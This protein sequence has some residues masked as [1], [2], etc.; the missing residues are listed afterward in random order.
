MTDYS[1]LGRI[2]PVSSDSEERTVL[3]ISAVSSPEHIAAEPSETNSSHR[4]RL[5][6]THSSQFPSPPPSVTSSIGSSPHYNPP[7]P[8]PND[9]L[10]PIYARIDK[11]NRD[12]VQH[13]DPKT[14]RPADL[15]LAIPVEDEVGVDFICRYR[16]LP[17]RQLLHKVEL[18]DGSLHI[19]SAR[20]GGAKAYP[21]IA[22]AALRK[23]LWQFWFYEKCIPTSLYENAIVDI[24]SYPLWINTEHHGAWATDYTPDATITCDSSSV[25][26]PFMVEVANTQ[27]YG[28]LQAK[29][30]FWQHGSGGKVKTIILMT[31]ANEDVV[32]DH[33]CVLE[34]WKCA[35]RRTP[36]DPWVFPDPPPGIS[37]DDIN[38]ERQ[39]A[40]DAT[41]AMQTFLGY[42][43]GPLYW[44]RDHKPALDTYS[45]RSIPL[46]ASD[47]FGESLDFALLPNEHYDPNAECHIDLELWHSAIKKGVSESIKR[48]TAFADV[49]FPTDTTTPPRPDLGRRPIDQGKSLSD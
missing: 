25:W 44:I 35:H 4:F 49:P 36:E 17:D 23:H 24:Q 48:K 2:S 27:K 1:H 31:Y 16:S 28:D 11:H 39:K 20:M 37:L 26:A 13:F 29:R 46:R 10:A 34:V 30:S 21:D 43:E 41:S 7:S 22:P 45:H 33:T 19:T 12:T 32:A 3:C 9:Y 8:T 38:S 18:Y 40:I 47:W 5:Q 42:R 14:F 15:Y 6:Q